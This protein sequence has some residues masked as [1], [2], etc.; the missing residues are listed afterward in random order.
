MPV[1]SGQL[2]KREHVLSSPS[3]LLPANADSLPTAV[4]VVNGVDNAAVVTVANK[5]TGVYTFTVT[6]P[7]LSLGDYIQIRCTA[8]YST[9]TY[10][11]NL[12]GDTCLVLLTTNDVEL[13]RASMSLTVLESASLPNGTYTATLGATGATVTVIILNKTV[14]ATIA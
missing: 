5:S 1:V 4:L 11:Y 10:F 2:F 7:A 12:F 9:A 6:L 3:T 8:V 13:L 14:T